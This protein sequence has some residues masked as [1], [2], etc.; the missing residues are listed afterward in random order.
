[1]W[2]Q[3]LFLY[4]MN[5]VV[6]CKPDTFKETPTGGS[7]NKKLDIVLKSSS[8]ISSFHSSYPYSTFGF[9]IQIL[10]AATESQNRKIQ[11]Y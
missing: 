7:D 4:A 10:K 6:S 5:G 9:K 3:Q 1:M 11:F 2:Y 8:G